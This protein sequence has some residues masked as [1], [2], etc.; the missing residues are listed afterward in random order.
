MHEFSSDTA[1]DS[2]VTTQ[3]REANEPLN[4]AFSCVVV[5][6]KCCVYYIIYVYVVWLG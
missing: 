3:K 4:S 5:D 6:K 2:T 1:Y